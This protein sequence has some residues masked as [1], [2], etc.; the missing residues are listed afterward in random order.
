MLRQGVSCR[1]ND[2]GFA[3]GIPW[4]LQRYLGN[5][6]SDPEAH[7]PVESSLLANL[8]IQA[9]RKVSMQHMDFRKGQA[10]AF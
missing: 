2:E 8:V 6:V 9:L 7:V 3:M 5:K 4:K 1:K 10:R